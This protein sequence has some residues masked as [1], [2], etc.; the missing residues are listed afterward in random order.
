MQ[1]NFWDRTLA[2]VGRVGRNRS[3]RLTLEPLQ[4]LVPDDVTLVRARPAL[5]H[6]PLHADEATCVA[7]AVPGRRHEFAAGRAC[8]RVAL[9]RLGIQDF[10]LLPDADQ[11]PRWPAGIVGSIAHCEACCVVG[12]ARAEQVAGL[13]LDVEPATPLE[14]E[15]LPLVA[16]SR[17]LAAH[18]GP[19]RELGKLI[20]CA[21]EA[22]YKCYFPCARHPLEFRDVEVALEPGTPRSGPG[23]FRATLLAA[24]APSL[25]GGLRALE[26]RYL[27]EGPFLFTA[28]TLTR[29]SAAGSRG[30]PPGVSC[31]PSGG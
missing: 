10:P 3:R 16:S 29:R 27:R 20:F 1:T 5:W 6:A 28:V 9:E 22:F 31:A 12:V 8:A 30:D 4:Q 13:G 2:S 19:E 21:K 17:E 24:R 14:A 7:A 26:G 18:P 23:R 15:L 25:P 11:V